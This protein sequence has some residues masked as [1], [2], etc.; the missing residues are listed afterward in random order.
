[1]NMSELNK[2]RKSYEWPLNFI[3]AVTAEEEELIVP[4][5]DDT[6]SSVEFVISKLLD[7]EKMAITEFFKNSKP[8][9]SIAKLFGCTNYK[10][11]KFISTTLKQIYDNIFFCLVLENGLEYL[12]DHNLMPDQWYDSALSFML[13]CDEDDS[14][15]DE[16]D[17]DDEVFE[18]NAVDIGY[19]RDWYR[20]SV[21]FDEEPIWTDA[22]LEELL[23]DFYVIPKQK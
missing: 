20:N 15:E 6:E 5:A 17:I 14:D 22:H 7:V 23:N 8:I 18:S 11:A 19:L 12:F 2:I 9:S 16:T 13:N 1:M 10:A 4:I 3:A 21:N